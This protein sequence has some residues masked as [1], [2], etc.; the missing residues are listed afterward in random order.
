[1]PFSTLQHW[2]SKGVE[3][4]TAMPRSSG[5]F[6]LEYINQQLLLYKQNSTYLYLF[7]L[8]FLSLP[9]SLPPFSYWPLQIQAPVL[10]IRQRSYGN[11]FSWEL[12]SPG[13]WADSAGAPSLTTSP[14]LAQQA[15]KSRRFGTPEFWAS[16]LT[17]LSSF[18]G[19][20]LVF[21]SFFIFLSLL[22]LLSNDLL[23]W[24]GY[25]MEFYE[26]CVSDY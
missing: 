11:F 5:H 21:L 4:G 19:Y 6:L 10:S 23:P 22:S 26:F 15:G 12:P 13:P 3:V 1:M 16:L 2:H 17:A 25:N 7:S 18:G 8:P 24:S 9:P 14:A 20:I